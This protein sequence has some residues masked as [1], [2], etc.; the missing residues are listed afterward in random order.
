MMIFVLI[1]MPCIAAITA[2]KNE[3]G[4]KW[5]V[6]TACYTTLLAWI[7]TFAFYHIGMMIV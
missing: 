4:T 5:A 7:V 3:G 1:Y 2:V 6:F